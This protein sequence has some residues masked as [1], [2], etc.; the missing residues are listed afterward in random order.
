MRDGVRPGEAHRR[1]L[2]R[3]DDETPANEDFL[4]HLSRGSELLMENRV[5]EAK[6]QLET[7]LSFQPRDAQSQDLLAGVYFRLGVYD[8]AITIWSSLLEDFPN[9]PTLHVNMG[10]ALFKTGQPEQAREYLERALELEPD[11]ERSWGYLG[12]VHWRLGRLDAAREAF[13]RGG[14]LSMARRMEEQSSVG[15]LE[16][17][18]FEEA[19]EDRVEDA[20]VSAMKDAASEAEER[21]SGASV[22]LSVEHERPRHPTGSWKVVETGADHVPRRRAS[23]HGALAIGPATLESV[24][25][26]WALSLPEGTPLA[27]GPEGQ[28]LVQAEG[29]V[30]SRMTNLRAVRGTVN[31]ELVPRSFRGREDREVLGGDAEPIRRW[32]GPVAAVMAPEPGVR[33]HALTVSSDHLYV[34]EELVAAFDDRVGYESGRLP[35][36]GEPAVL[37]SFHGEGVVVLRLPRQPSGLE[38]RSDGEVRVDPSALVGWTGRLFPSEVTDPDPPAVCLA[39]KGQGIVLVT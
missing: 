31:T 33:F 4:F 3:R 9:D 35:L 18:V 12:L 34:R 26:R 22:T 5:V 1:R 32:H 24:A 8:T 10:L 37:L 7:A 19:T 20:D 29:A 27:V 25:E 39:F 2:L 15:E 38:V 30:H 23:S 14:Q 16:A 6:E 13:L 17:P 28:L 36:A 21:L 11:H